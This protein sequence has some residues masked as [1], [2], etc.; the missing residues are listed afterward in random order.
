M[1][2]VQ[3]WFAPRVAEEAPF[4]SPRSSFTK[5]NVEPDDSDSPQRKTSTPNSPRSSLH[6]LTDT[7]YFVQHASE[8]N[9]EA[10]Y[11]SVCSHKQG[12]NAC[13]H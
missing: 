8:E 10:I 6:P 3:H 4:S 9:I 5:I 11:L 2:L 7:D 12:M 1:P 13:M